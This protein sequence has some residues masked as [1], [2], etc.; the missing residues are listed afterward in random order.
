MKSRM[1]FT[2]SK[3]LTPDFQPIV[4]M[5][6]THGMKEFRKQLP[7]GVMRS[8]YP[9]LKGNMIERIKSSSPCLSCRGIR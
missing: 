5:F 9:E 4:S 8:A 3:G 6:T 2:N 1:V 7:L